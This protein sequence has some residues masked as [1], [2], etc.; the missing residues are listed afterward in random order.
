MGATKNR[1]VN[2]FLLH[3]LMR[4][5]PLGIL[6]I[7]RSVEKNHG[8]IDP[9]MGSR[10]VLRTRNL[11]HAHRVLRVRRF[12]A[13]RA[14]E[15]KGKCV[16]SFPL[17]LGQGGRAPKILRHKLFEITCYALFC[18]C[19]RF[20]SARPFK[21]G[22]LEPGHIA[23]PPSRKYESRARCFE[24]DKFETYSNEGVLA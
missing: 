3:N 10:V 2:S 9:S 15:E 19:A 14:S 7:F 16:N 1:A 12:Y 13:V 11:R 20:R 18:V 23:S 8:I 24:L 6:P 5:P 17:L 4:S 22:V 21:I